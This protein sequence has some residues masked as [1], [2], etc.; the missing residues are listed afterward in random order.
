MSFQGIIPPV[1]TPFH[2]DG[3]IDRD[4]FSAMVEHLI[5][6]G[7]H[8]IVVGGTTGEYYAQSRDERV[9]LLKLAKAV[10]K[11]R[12]PLI[13]GVGA[14]RTEDCIEYALV[15]GD[16]KYDGI[17]IGSPF[18]AVPTQL[19]LANHA[20]A[21]DKAANLPI[22]LYNYPGRT[23]TMMGPEFLDRVGRSANFRAIKESSGS[24][25]HL[26]ALARDY[27]H[28]DL[29]CG[30]D[31]QALEFFA[32]G[33]RGWV[34]GAGNCLPG[35]H[36]ALYDACVVERDFVKGRR[37]MSALLPL[38]RLLEQGGKFVQSIKFGC[39][40]AGLP[41]GPVRRPMR[42]LDDAQKRELETCIRTLKA[43]IGSIVGKSH[44]RHR[45]NVI[46]INA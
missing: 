20:L 31:D 40:L 34:C 9:S 43:A 28:I 38:M 18:Y 12:V 32:W 11:G 27:P 15:A 23:G 30:M 8:G 3:S 36:L 5:A 14:I 13:A 2:A 29:F 19:E 37:I 10:A 6:S 33:A 24:I 21:I 7:V 44:E 42:A 26:H 22:M 35:E 4:G 46:A 39:E 25:D 45:E 16:L 17:L 41:A 1:T